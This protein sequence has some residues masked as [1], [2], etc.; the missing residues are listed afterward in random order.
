MSINKSKET[1]RGQTTVPIVMIIT[2]IGVWCSGLSLA[3]FNVN[4]A[5]AG[6]T[7][8]LADIKENTSGLSQLKAEVDW[9]AQQRG[10]KQPILEATST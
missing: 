1:N 8:S 2:A 5:V 9:L 6:L 3:A 10:Y 4:G 7:A